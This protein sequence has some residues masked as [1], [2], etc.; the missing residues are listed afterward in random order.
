MSNSTQTRTIIASILTL[1]F[2]VGFI[3]WET[4]NWFTTDEGLRLM[5]GGDFW[6]INL[7]AGLVV[8]VEIAALLAYL[9]NRYLSEEFTIPQEAVL[10]TVV[11][12][13][14]TSLPDILLTWYTLAYQI[15]TAT[16]Q[17]LVRGPVQVANA[18]GV[19]PWI[20]AFMTWGITLAVMKVMQSGLGVAFQLLKS[21]GG[22]GLFKINRQRSSNRKTVIGKSNTTTSGIYNRDESKTHSPRLENRDTHD[23]S[24]LNIPNIPDDGSDNLPWPFTTVPGSRK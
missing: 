6:W 20:I 10:W 12:W 22:G 23:I 16:A 7:L 11:A 24:N 8:G 13:V 19:F 4:F 1:I 21:S 17:G 15:E 5:M 2:T 18:T 14:L 3:L 9:A